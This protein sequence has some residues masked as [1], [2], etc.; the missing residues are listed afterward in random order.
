MRVR[1]TFPVVNIF[2]L[3]K[4]LLASKE[5]ADEPEAVL[6][7]AA[8]TN[9]IPPLPVYTF[10]PYLL[11]QSRTRSL[12]THPGS[13]HLFSKDCFFFAI[14]MRLSVILS[15]ALLACGFLVL[16]RS[17]NERQETRYLDKYTPVL[18]DWGWKGPPGGT[19]SSLG[20]TYP[21]IASAPE[22]SPVE[23][24][25]NQFGDGNW[26]SN[27]PLLAG[28][29]AGSSWEGEDS[30]NNPFEVQPLETGEPPSQSE[31]FTVPPA[32]QATF[33]SLKT[34]RYCIYEISP[35]RKTLHFQYCGTS[36]YWGAFATA[37]QDSKS[38]FALYRLEDGTIVSITNLLNECRSKN[39]NLNWVTVDSCASGDDQN[40]LDSF[41][42]AWINSIKGKLG[43]QDIDSPDPVRTDTDLA[44]IANRYR[45][46]LP[47]PY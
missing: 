23:I 6:N 17:L 1:V 24:S 38:G 8:H 2:S 10:I 4:V 33:P 13:T 25:T 7:I 30:T 19:D 31:T 39:S 21:K 44:Y 35:N 27:N 43:V 36:S 28:I 11:P 47:L 22:G 16:G 40:I 14:N 5:T 12:L 42:Y 18:D 32:V 41:Q 20:L 15:A 45:Q 3:R 29:L 9:H 26:V 37:L 46:K 34:H